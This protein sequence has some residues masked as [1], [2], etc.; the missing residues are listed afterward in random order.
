MRRRQEQLRQ[1][2][3]QP[4]SVLALAQVPLQ[5]QRQ[6][7]QQQWKR[8]DSTRS[9]QWRLS[10]AARQTRV[11]E[12]RQQ[13][14]SVQSAAAQQWRHASHARWQPARGERGAINWTTY[15]GLWRR[16]F[17]ADPDDLWGSAPAPGRQW[18]AQQPDELSAANY[19]SRSAGEGQADR[20]AWSSCG[21]QQPWDLHQQQQQQQSQQWGSHAGPDALPPLLASATAE[22][23]LHR[24]VES[25]LRELLGQCRYDLLAFLQ[26]LGVCCVAGSDRQATLKSAWRSS[27]LRFHPDQLQQRPRREQVVGLVATRLI[28]ELWRRPAA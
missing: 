9:D 24:E 1:R 19:S 7:Q 13:R 8:E 17:Q 2:S 22:E 25:E 15:A 27:M 3:C 5:Q 26:V 28:N 10:R 4:R 23:R 18:Q 20:W 6:Q 16:C 11:L 12:Q 21:S 14:E